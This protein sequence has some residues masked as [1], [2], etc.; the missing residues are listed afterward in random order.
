MAHPKASPIRLSIWSSESCLQLT[1]ANTKIYVASRKE[2]LRVLSAVGENLPDPAALAAGTSTSSAEPSA[3]ASRL[4]AGMRGAVSG[5]AA[6]LSGAVAVASK[7][8]KA[9]A[10][11][12]S[13]LRLRIEAVR[14]PAGPTDSPSS[15]AGEASAPRSAPGTAPGPVPGP[16]EAAG[17]HGVEFNL[18]DKEISDVAFEALSLLMEYLH[19]NVVYTEAKVLRTQLCA[20]P[21]LT[22]LS[23]HIWCRQA[24]QLPAKLPVTEAD[25]LQYCE[26]LNLMAESGHDSEEEE[27]EEEEEEEDTAEVL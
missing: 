17:A 22:E 13:R 20:L 23:C 21:T 2:V 7:V 10:G 16:V 12:I 25:L 3:G 1:E 11:E 14:V 8:R 19:D 6:A 26:E 27:D 9:V 4:R 18:G 15:V 5:A 24:Y